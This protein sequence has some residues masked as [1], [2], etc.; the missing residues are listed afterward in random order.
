MNG[1]PATKLPPVSPDPTFGHKGAT[2]LRISIVSETCPPDVNGVA[3]TLEKLCHGLLEQGHQVEIIR[4]KP[5]TPCDAAPS[6]LPRQVIVRSLPVPGYPVLRMGWPSF[7]KLRTQWTECR[8]DVVYVATEGPL[9]W[10]AVWTARLMGIPVGSG[11]HT[12]FCD[13]LPSYG[14]GRL[15]FLADKLQRWF[16]NH[17]TFTLVP[18][19]DTAARLTRKGYQRVSLLRRGVDGDRFHPKK[20][21]ESL[22]SAW[23]ASP[24]DLVVL[25][26]G[27]VA[28]EKNLTLALRTAENLRPLFPKMKAVVVGDGPKL[29]EYKEQF[30]HAIFVGEQKGDALARHYASGDLLLFPSLT[31]TFGNVLL[32]AMASGLPSISFDYAAGREHIIDGENGWT[33]PYANESAFNARFAYCLGLNRSVLKSVGAEAQRAA[34]EL[35]WA[36]I[37]RHFETILSATVIES[38]SITQLPLNRNLTP[39]TNPLTR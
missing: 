7:L 5:Y 2:A 21:D 6:S 18:S 13:Y 12:N 17:C 19:R 14:G 38:A 32:E 29:Q 8:P 24:D 16:H 26:V 3:L 33:V 35:T 39:T 22:R 15:V 4:P 31:E 11:Y 25:L 36:T 1:T 34:Q 30:H 9:G 37:V 10:A 28:A 20:R 23:G 27:R